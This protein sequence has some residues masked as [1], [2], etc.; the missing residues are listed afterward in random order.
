MKMNN[1][2]SS[3][4]YGLLKTEILLLLGLILIR[5]KRQSKIVRDGTFQADTH[6]IDFDSGEI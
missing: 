2:V 4:F 3:D 1:L 6:I 5:Y